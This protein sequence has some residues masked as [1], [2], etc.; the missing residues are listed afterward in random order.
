MAE[1]ERK[2]RAQEAADAAAEEAERQALAGVEEAADELVA[3][4][5]EGAVARW[6]PGLKQWQVEELRLV[7]APASDR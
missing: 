5:V 4:A 1:A 2:R 6:V 7:R 3:A